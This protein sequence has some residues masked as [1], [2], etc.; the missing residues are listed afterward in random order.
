M[1]YNGAG[2]FTLYSPGNPVVTGTTISSTWAN[3]TLSD[4]ATGL[5]TAVTKNGQTVVTANIP[6][7]G[8]KLTG[9]GAGA[10]AGDSLRYQQGINNVSWYGTDRAAMAA[11]DVAGYLVFPKGVYT[12]ATNLTISGDCVFLPGA[13]I[14][15]SNG[16]TVTINGCVES[17]VQQIF[18]LSLGGHVDLSG[19][20]ADLAYPEW[21][22]VIGGDASYDAGNA[23]TNKPLIDEVLTYG[24]YDLHWKQPGI[25]S[26]TGHVMNVAHKHVG[27]G[28]SSDNCI[29]GD[30]ILFS[31][32]AHMVTRGA[33]LAGKKYVFQNGANGAIPIFESMSVL[34]DPT[35]C[36]ALGI[37][38][39]S[40]AALEWGCDAY[41]CQFQGYIGRHL[42]WANRNLWESC[43][44]VGSFACTAETI[45]DDNSGLTTAY[46]YV[47]KQLHTSC[48][49]SQS[50]IA[51]GR[52]LYQDRVGSSAPYS[53]AL[54]NN[55]WDLCNFEYGYNGFVLA[56]FEQVFNQPHVENLNGA[57]LISEA[58]QYN[59]VWNT[60]FIAQGAGSLAVDVTTL[61]SQKSSQSCVGPLGEAT[62]LSSTGFSVVFTPIVRWT[63]APGK[64][65]MVTLNIPDISGTSNST[66]KSLATLP[67]Y[68]RPKAEAWGFFPA[69]DNSAA[70]VVGLCTIST[71]GVITLYASAGAGNWTNSGTATI[72]N[73]SIT[74]PIT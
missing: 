44:F 33:T 46:G 14:K 45:W 40:T 20:K 18:D 11:A 5:S 29:Y 73:F 54:S 8:F 62:I 21:W 17:G 67:T 68:L 10:A 19:S 2:L 53:N 15:P 30:G 34:G 1:P 7:A 26:T 27:L 59:S 51:S 63:I 38:P 32:N 6:M 3:N 36:I 71:A 72:S 48:I 47:Q 35:D 39:S 50:Q 37:L 9:L 66:G 55:A 49:Y 61:L 24:P 56:G 64:V 25:Y 70:Y 43:F 23:A 13:T 41:D 60:P 58:T 22:G 74:Y 4:I 12:C 31:D 28:K 65:Q 16:V 69:S 42:G 57:T 52:I